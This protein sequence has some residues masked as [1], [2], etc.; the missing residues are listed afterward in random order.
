MLPLRHPSGVG[1]HLLSDKR[2]PLVIGFLLLTAG[3]LVAYLSPA[4]GY[5]PS[6]Y[7]GTPIIFWASCVISFFIS[8]TLAI[9]SSEKIFQKTA[10]LLGGTSMMS[11]VILPVL[12]GYYW[13]GE[14]DSLTHLGY[15]RDL[16]SGALSLLDI[17]Y[18]AIHTIGVF[19]EHAG[20][21]T[22]VDSLQL[23]V[24]IFSLIYFIFIPLVVREISK[25]RIA[26]Y[27]A[28]FSAF[29]LIQLNFLGVHMNVHPTSQAILFAPAVL[30]AYIKNY[31]SN[32]WGWATVFLILSAGL[33]LIHPQQAANMI[34][35]LGTVA[36]VQIGSSISNQDL[37]FS[38][39]KA[40]FAIV[41]VFAFIFW[42]WV[43][44]LPS[45]ESAFSALVALALLSAE[46]ASE[47]GSRLLSISALGG[48]I[49]GIFVKMFLVALI[50]CLLSGILFL[51]VILNHIFDLKIN[52]FLHIFVPNREKEMFYNFSIGFVSLIL[53][54]IIYFGIQYSTQYFRH[55]GF[56]M[57]VVT[58][59]G[60]VA[61]SQ[62]IDRISH[63]GKQVAK[64]SC[65]IFLIIMLSLSLIVVYPSPYIYQTSGHVTEAQF[66][67]HDTLFKYGDEQVP[68][69]FVRSATHRYGHAI[70]GIKEKPRRAYYAEGVRQGGVPDHFA[71][72]SLEAHFD[73]S[74]YLVVTQADRVR[75]PVVYQ[76]IRFNRSDFQYVET[77][78]DLN[79]IYSNH[80]MDVYYI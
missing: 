29:M 46:G 61:I 38:L 15:A 59:V 66:Q 53:L 1:L 78:P 45:F 65:S 41:T 17:R 18:P 42:L 72:Q 12:R 19:L 68:H 76:G 48:S 3:N 51:S 4:S 55:F 56:M 33:T 63:R 30:Y 20:G 7:A 11:V 21:T 35:F 36:L 47:L 58:I 52:D 75:D 43:R 44:N 57:V 73:T 23:I 74:T 70:E 9:S 22:L 40:N 39:V 2:V 77:H 67:G 60:S 25:N 64:I 80:G 31:W 34:L 16:S 24:P 32:S 37:R 8:I 50:Y 10:V 71:S 79:K 13:V 69:A 14:G 49:E 62:V 54:F 26:I 28:I 27:V 6:I 5:E